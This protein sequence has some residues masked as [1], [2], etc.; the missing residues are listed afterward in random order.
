VGGAGTGKTSI[1]ARIADLAVDKAT[2]GILP[3]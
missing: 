3:G 1:L 2:A